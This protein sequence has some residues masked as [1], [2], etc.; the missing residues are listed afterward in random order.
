M[1][2][3]R[4]FSQGSRTISDNS[5]TAQRGSKCWQCWQSC[6]QWC[7]IE[8]SAPPQNCHTVCAGHS[9]PRPRPG[10]RMDAAKS[11]GRCSSESRVPP[12]SAARPTVVQPGTESTPISR[13][14]PPGERTAAQR[15]ATD[16]TIATC[17]T[18]DSA[19]AWQNQS[20]PG[21]ACSTVRLGS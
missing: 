2:L 8:T 13:R 14:L 18:S 9:R 17:S 3:L 4:G 5:V 19:G 20:W 12:T 6:W 7:V 10:C 21:A 1:L 15:N 16:S 11:G